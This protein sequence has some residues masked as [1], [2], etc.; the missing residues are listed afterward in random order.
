MSGYLGNPWDAEASGEPPVSV[1]D[2]VLSTPAIKGSEEELQSKKKAKKVLVSPNP[3]APGVAEGK[4]PQC[5]AASLAS[6]KM[7]KENKVYTPKDMQ[8]KYGHVADEQ[9]GSLKPE[10]WIAIRDSEKL[11]TRTLYG[12]EFTSA[13]IADLLSQ[14]KWVIMMFFYFPRPLSNMNHW[15]VIDGVNGFDPMRDT[16]YFQIMDPL[17]DQEKLRRAP[18][19]KEFATEISGALAF[20]PKDPNTPVKADRLIFLF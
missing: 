10:G 18:F 16:D 13:A 4:L 2:E 20:D 7:A 17:A 19:V 11:R 14:S 5:W 15:V 9:N 6:F 1:G 12:H 3:P 8:N